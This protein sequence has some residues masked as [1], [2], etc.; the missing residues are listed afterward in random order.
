MDQSIITKQLSSI[1]LPQVNTK[2]SSLLLNNFKDIAED[3]QIKLSRKRSMADS[4]SVKELESKTNGRWSKEENRKFV[5]GK[6]L[7]NS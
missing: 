2:A 3:D 4:Y 1:Q 7:S 6:K 5:E